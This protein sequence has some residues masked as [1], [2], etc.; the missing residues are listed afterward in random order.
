MT[1]ATY[2]PE[3][4]PHNM[5]Q[6]FRLMA[7]RAI[8]A[9]TSIV[10]WAVAV[11]EFGSLTPI[12]LTIIVGVG[13]AFAVAGYRYRNALAPEW[14]NFVLLCLL[15]LITSY[16]IQANP[17]D[18]VY[19]MFPVLGMVF[20]MFD[21]IIFLL[22]IMLIYAL[23]AWACYAFLP[24]DYALRLALSMLILIAVGTVFLLM[25]MRMQKMLSK[26][27]V[28]DQLTRVY[29]RDH[30]E[31]VLQEHITKALKLKKPVSLV[32]IDLDNFK[33][34]NDRFG[35]ML[36][37]EV[38]RETAERLQ[39]LVEGT[40]L[41]V[42]SNGAA[43]TIVLP[44]TSLNQAGD[45]AEKILKEIRSEPFSVK[46]MVMAITASAGVAQWREQQSWGDWMEAADSAMDAAKRQGRNRAKL[47]H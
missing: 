41:I 21:R 25:M 2:L 6:Q 22:V 46:S 4:A 23:F 10:L 7:M 8:Y 5:W 34:V 37:D 32:T 14:V 27:S 35:Y 16:S 17:T 31:T 11:M 38:I 40:D 30:L 9:G 19:W 18:G 29:S 36:G 13:V 3:L 20:F 39:R 15:G 42:R 26:V 45:V 43:F 33:Q 28:T 24:F 47:A 1:F 12:A 44:D